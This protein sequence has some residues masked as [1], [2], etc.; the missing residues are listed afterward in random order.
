MLAKGSD[1][2]LASFPYCF[3]PATL[4]PQVMQ[5]LRVASSSPS[6]ALIR[7][8]AV[9]TALASAAWL[10]PAAPAPPSRPSLTQAAITCWG[11][12]AIAS[13]SPAAAAGE[14]GPTHS[15]IHNAHRGREINVTWGWGDEPNFFEW[16]ETKERYEGL[17]PDLFG[18][19]SEQLG[20]RFN[21]RPA[22]RLVYP[23]DFPSEGS[24]I[25]DPMAFLFITNQTQAFLGSTL[26]Y[27]YYGPAP[28]GIW[29]LDQWLGLHS[30]ARH[31]NVVDLF[32]ERL[33]VLLRKS[34]AADSSWR[35]FAPFTVS[36]W[37]AV[38]GLIATLGLGM[39]LL[40]VLKQ[41]CRL[42]AAC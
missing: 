23:A 27:Y 32:T 10:G 4:L 14:V 13:L 25:V 6:L 35:L 19:V 39:S 21:F 17:I 26:S 18:A 37:M 11:A 34:R 30:G 20:V 24:P 28:F 38:V 15:L 29:E 36:L 33:G 9:T 1:T 12:V 41:V 2:P 42:G 31:V 22:P 5:T 16:S 7:W 3:V 40:G 8:S